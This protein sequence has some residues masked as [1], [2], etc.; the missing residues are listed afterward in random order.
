MTTIQVAHNYILNDS[1]ST[2]SVE[3]VK[4]CA[5]NL[6]L[7]GSIPLLWHVLD[8]M[9]TQ[10]HKQQGSVKGATT[11]H[12]AT[13]D[14]AENYLIGICLDEKTRALL[15]HSRTVL[16]ANLYPYALSRYTVI[17]YISSNDKSVVQHATSLATTR[18]HQASDLIGISCHS[19]R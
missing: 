18:F 9:Q 10:H 15:E 14:I 5:I 11:T 8:G 1:G 4:G 16:D 2:G 3:M 12:C 13:N 6:T 17:L 7:L 19:C